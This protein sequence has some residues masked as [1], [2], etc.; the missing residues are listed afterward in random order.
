MNVNEKM[1]KRKISKLKKEKIKEQIR[2]EIYE[3]IKMR[4]AGKE[5]NDDNTRTN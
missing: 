4:K 3:K 1:T 5:M 2:Q